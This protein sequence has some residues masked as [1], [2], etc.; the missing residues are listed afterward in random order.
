MIF[1]TYIESLQQTLERI[2][3]EQASAIEEAG[4]R[5]GQALLR[6]G[7]VHVFGTGHSHMI[8]EEAF[9]RAGGIPAVNPILDER[10]VFLKGAIE[11]TRAE[12]EQG[13]AKDLISREVVLPDDIAV[14]ISNSGCNSAPV[15]MA[16]E[17]K[18]RGVDVIAIT[19]VQQSSN[20]KPRDSSGKRLF[21]IADVIIDTYAATGDA[22]LRLPGLPHAIG[23]SST[24]A[25]A[26]IINSIVIEAA[27]T[28][29]GEG[30]SVPILPSANLSTTTQEELSSLLRPYRG[31]I[32]LLDV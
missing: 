9:F 15:E 21:E 16:C 6:G 7:V 17:M 28:V 4:A 18:S 27:A 25:A 26:A 23:A 8:A 22:L 12:R 29:A 11:S 1:E 30:K 24:V 10:L 3:Q 31:R 2:K 20:A 19:N 5:V 14:V 32:R 13:Y